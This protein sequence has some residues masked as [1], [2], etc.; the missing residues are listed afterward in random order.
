[1]EQRFPAVGKLREEVSSM[2]ESAPAS[3]ALRAIAS[4]RRSRYGRTAACTGVH[5]LRKRQ[6]GALDLPFSGA[7]A[8]RILCR[9][10]VRQQDLYTHCNAQVYGNTGIAAYYLVGTMTSGGKTAIGTWRVTEAKCGH[11][12]VAGDGTARVARRGPARRAGPRAFEYV[13]SAMNRFGLRR[14]DVVQEENVTI[15]W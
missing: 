4:R 8:Q 15:M 9:F 2:L 6:R 14:R 12:T 3:P 13:R 7:A 5:V 1:M 10:V 11:V